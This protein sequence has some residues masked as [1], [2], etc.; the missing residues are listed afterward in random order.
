MFFSYVFWG[1]PWLDFC[2]RS[3]ASG[4]LIIGTRILPE[5]LGECHAFFSE[6]PK[7]S[8]RLARRGERL[9]L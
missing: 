3:R 2:F 5:R 9:K 7:R 8:D 1:F 4:V 6:N